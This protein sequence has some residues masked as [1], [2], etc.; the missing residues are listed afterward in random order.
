MVIVRLKNITICFSE[1]WIVRYRLQIWK[2][3]FVTIPYTV[4]VKLPTRRTCSK[5]L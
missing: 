3:H 5:A 4:A 1:E 2:R